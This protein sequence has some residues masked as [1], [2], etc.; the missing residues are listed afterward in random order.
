M[1]VAPAHRRQ[2]LLE[3]LVRTVSTAARDDGAADLRL[4]VHEGNSRAIQAYRRC[5]FDD[6]PYRIMS[7][8]PARGG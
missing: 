8:R 1:Y 2:G 5:G 3:Q 7:L 6:A 4:Y